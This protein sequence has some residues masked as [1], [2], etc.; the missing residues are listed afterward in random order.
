MRSYYLIYWYQLLH[1]HIVGNNTFRVFFYGPPCIG[2]RGIDRCMSYEL[3]SLLRSISQNNNERLWKS[4][5]RMVV[6]IE[7]SYKT[8]KNFSVT[9]LMSRFQT[10]KQIN[11]QTNKPRTNFMK[12]GCIYSSAQVFNKLPESVRVKDSL[13]NFWK[14]T[15]WLL[16]VTFNLIV[17]V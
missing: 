8:S 17:C 11:R 7:S 2:R 10:N 15:R 12:H 14:S 6:M 9:V 5:I 13:K 1:P 3:H 16:W 4:F